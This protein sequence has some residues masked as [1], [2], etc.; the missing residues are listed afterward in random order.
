MAVGVGSLLL[1]LLSL[2]LMIA[3]GGN[4]LNFLNRMKVGSRLA[5]IVGM[6]L[7]LMLVVGVFSIIKMKQVE[8]DLRYIADND[9]PLMEAVAEIGAHQL[10]MG[11]LFERAARHAAINEHDEVK[12]LS[13]EIGKVG[14]MVG[15]QFEKGKKIATDYM[16]QTS[17]IQI[18]QKC[19][20]I[21]ATFKKLEGEHEQVE[22]KMLQALAH[23]D[24]GQ[25]Q[26]GQLMA[27][28]LEKEME[29]IDHGLEALSAEIEHS[30]GEAAQHAEHLQGQTAQVTIVLL[31]VAMAMG[32]S[33]GVLVTR[34]ITRVLRDV[35]E[36]ADNVT[37]ASLQ[38]S[39]SA[40]QISQGATEQA[41]A[42]E[43]SSSSV[44]E[45][46]SMIN[47]N[48]DNSKETERI[49]AKAASDA[50]EGGRAVGQAVDAMRQIADKI[51]IIEEIARQTNLLAL[52]AAIEAA[53]AGEHGKGFAVVAAEVRKLAERSQSSAAEISV[54]SGSSV[55][56][57]E[58][59]GTMLATMVPNIQKTASLIQEISAASLEQSSGTDQINQAMQQL[60]TVIQQNAGA[61]EEMAATAEE[62]SAQAE[63]LQEN[64][65]S[66]IGANAGNGVGKQF[67]A[68][69]MATRK[70]S[71][72]R[73]VGQ[74]FMRPAIAAQAQSQI[75]V[76]LDM[77]GE[78]DELDKQF[79]EY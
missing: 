4:A 29:S 78:G 52:N 27:E 10:E 7:G 58:R 13:D 11:V 6:L 73:Q 54:L 38:V 25:I 35:K 66:L 17:D 26:E 15:E 30:A 76:D 24:E 23:F 28:A 55:E 75:G 18:K 45:M 56:V 57:S 31:L 49:A 34:S 53:R 62:L 37:S 60:D 22:E 72:R 33:L 19:E 9:I 44:N 14:V 41:A 20:G 79:S 68:S 8:G 2:V 74:T 46:A 40:Q 61:S 36:V 59:A 71:A 47:Q 5:L 3:K 77:G 70:V 64:I 63:S 32:I 21:L 69:S 48:A 1:I 51:S 43:E 67:A 12:L 50:E 65:A 16:A 42:A 39:A